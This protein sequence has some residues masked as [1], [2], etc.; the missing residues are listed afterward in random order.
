[1]IESNG[2]GPEKSPPPAEGPQK[3]FNT[4]PPLPEGRGLRPW[5]SPAEA[6]R[7]DRAERRARAREELTERDAG[8]SIN[9][10]LADGFG[11][12]NERYG[13]GAD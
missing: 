3:K 13:E 5:I 4:K 2:N 10:R 6:E 8:P 11:A 7:L 12:I 1:V 9:E